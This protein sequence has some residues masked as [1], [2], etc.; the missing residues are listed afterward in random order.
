VAFGYVDSA[1]ASP[2][3]SLQVEIGGVLRD[4]CVQGAPLYDPSGERMRA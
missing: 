4:A 2:G 1:F 3:Q